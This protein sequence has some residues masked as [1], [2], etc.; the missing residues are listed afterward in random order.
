[1][2]DMDPAS[3]L[4]INPDDAFTPMR[5][6][7]DLFE[8]VGQG[9]C[10]NVLT[11]ERPSESRDQQPLGPD[12]QSTLQGLKSLAESVLPDSIAR[13]KSKDDETV[14]SRPWIGTSQD[15]NTLWDNELDQRVLQMDRPNIFDSFYSGHE[16]PDLSSDDSL[17]SLIRNNNDS[18]HYEPWNKRTVF[19]SLS[20]PAGLVRPEAGDG[21]ASRD[22]VDLRFELP[23]LTKRPRDIVDE[24]LLSDGVVGTQSQS[25]KGK[26]KITS[27]SG[28]SARRSKNSIIDT[29]RAAG[30]PE[31]LDTAAGAADIRQ[32]GRANKSQLSWET[33]SKNGP[34]PQPKM[35]IISPYV[36]ETGINPFEA[37]YNRHMD[38]SF[39]FKPRPTLVSHAELVKCAFLL[40]GGTESSVF[41][42][43]PT[44]RK[45][46]LGTE[47][48]RIEG[49]SAKGV[50]GLLQDI[51][52]IGTHMRRLVHVTDSCVKQ[53]EGMGLVRIA[54]G[55]SLSSYLTFLQGSIVNLQ[56]TSK[57]KTTHIL[58]LH[59]QTHNM[60]IM[61]SRLSFICGC[62]VSRD[63]EEVLRDGLYL[64]P[65]PDL[66]SKLYVE[67]LEQP[68]ADSLWLALLFT[69]LDQ[70]SKPYRDMLGRWIGLS[71]S[72]DSE[73]TSL[74]LQPD[75]GLSPWG[76]TE[77]QRKGMS[78][79]SHLQQTL[80]DLD[81]FGEFFVQS[82]HHWSWEGSDN[83]ILADPLD[84]EAEFQMS[85]TLRPAKFIDD[86]LA[87]MILEAGKELQ[88]LKEFCPRHPL[89]T[90]DQ[91]ADGIGINW[92]YRHQDVLV[93]RRKCVRSSAKV[94]DALT[95][96][97]ESKGWVSQLRRNRSSQPQDTSEIMASLERLGADGSMDLD[98]F[99][100]GFFG[101]LGITAHE[102]QSKLDPSLAGFFS[103]SPTAV[104]AVDTNLTLACPDMMTFLLGPSTP[105][106]LDRVSDRQGARLLDDLNPLSV[107]ASQSLQYSIRY[108]A[109]LIRTSVM[110]LYLHD[111]NLWGHLE[112]M[113]R[114]MLMRDG[115]FLERL[116]EALF[117][118]STGLL[119][120]TS[121]M[122]A[123]TASALDSSM[124]MTSSIMGQQDRAAAQ[125]IWPPRSG[126]LE[127][128]LRAVLLDSFQDSTVEARDSDKQNSFLEVPTV[129]W[130]DLDHSMDIA[131]PKDPEDVSEEHV[132]RPRG[133]TAQELEDSLAF[134]IKKY[135]EKTKICRDVNALEALDFLCLDYKAPRPLRL[136]I[137]TP[138]ALEKYTRLFT[139]QLQLARVGAVLKQVFSQ[140]RFRHKFLQSQGP[141]GEDGY[142]SLQLIEMR[143]LHRYRFEAQQI[144]SG[145]QAYISDDGIGSSWRVFMEHLLAFQKKTEDRI[146]NRQT[147]AGDEDEE[148]ETYFDISEEDAD[149]Q[150]ED[151]SQL[152]DLASLQEYHDHILDQ[153]LLQT[154]LKRK[155]APILKL[156]HGILNCLL[157]L[158]QYVQ[159]LVSENEQ[160]EQ[161]D[162]EAREGDRE[163]MMARIT[164]RLSKLQSMQDKFRSLCRML[165]KVL[166]TLD[167][168]GIGVEGKSASTMGGSST[169]ET[170]KAFQ[171]VGGFLPQLLLR[172][173]VS[174]FNQKD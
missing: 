21:A 17:R 76:T 141:D 94:M 65:G 156:V 77:K 102:P 26:T 120:R 82:R 3:L 19:G 165:V 16:T 40:L 100:D 61:L 154:L 167:E 142:R 149:P 29:W 80:Q 164:Q 70:S 138:S 24:A 23:P 34:M 7:P 125:S 63:H 103:F 5:L 11:I 139:F 96:K 9:V 116:G 91:S 130:M 71:T 8:T 54:F 18:E 117:D 38:Y 86:E 132:C 136:L 15:W 159:G 52:D 171:T 35:P 88:I 168:R 13:T 81:P 111:L 39:K 129:D 90:Q 1:M 42:Y 150:L 160:E 114:F 134:A 10:D 55:R 22:S 68:T 73:K 66:L 135:D 33:C 43:N 46:E 124:F 95:S 122:A 107:L 118:E 89:L 115:V 2:Q 83:I 140:L 133:L 161:G 57:E 36:T 58:D 74:R 41:N 146:L 47:D 27:G 131:P 153:M 104:E 101:Y 123:A 137:F 145:L 93:L 51:M 78:I 97:L 59:H 155:Q 72:D 143:A 87:I 170:G 121:A 151:S 4:F 60:G 110:S 108:R 48:V 158:G 162:Q 49:C 62:H 75:S 85:T 31:Q 99:G 64:P 92:L 169:T 45:F 109:S 44:L 56:E 126:E 37:V 69:L 30:M 12:C 98:P 113:G 112:I 28:S 174:G 172:L 79:G 67:I 119:A 105:P 152:F 127:M 144:F 166:R 147:V 163:A 128:T 50:S 148:E 32:E 157:R 106:T 53:T 6:D 20:H 25:K 173:D 84:Y 14:E